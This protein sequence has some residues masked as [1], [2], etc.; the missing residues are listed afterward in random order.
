MSVLR[1]ITTSNLAITLAVEQLYPVAQAL[2]GF[3]P[4]EVLTSEDVPITISQQGVDGKK[5]VGL[6][7][8]GR[9]FSMTFAADSPSLDIFENWRAR[10]NSDGDVLYGSMVVSSKG[11]KKK[12][13]WNKLTITSMPDIPSAKQKFD[14]VTIKLNAESCVA[15]PM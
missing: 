14:N 1:T 13:V 3:A 5:S 7:R 12:F 15:S 10:Q 2:E 6:L 8:S 4:E 11:L 9:D